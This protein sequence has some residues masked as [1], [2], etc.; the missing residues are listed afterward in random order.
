M[1]ATADKGTLDQEEVEINPRLHLWQVPT[2]SFILSPGTQRQK[3]PKQNTTQTKPKQ[4]PNK[5]QT[6]PKQNPNKTQTKPKQ[7][8]NKTKTK[9]NQN[10]N[11]TKTKQNR[12]PSFTCSKAT[13]KRSASSPS[14]PRNWTIPSC[15][16][17]A[18]APW[19]RLSSLVRSILQTTSGSTKT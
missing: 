15:E 6:K 5:T 3:K 17:L 19:K 11:K 9:P 14:P 2:L 4:N 10:K 7:N 1:Y 13:S 16:P 12:T 8:Q 18:A